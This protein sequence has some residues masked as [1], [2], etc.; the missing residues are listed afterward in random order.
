VAGGASRPYPALSDVS[1][2]APSLAGDVDDAASLA[3]ARSRLSDSV[4]IEPGEG[5]LVLARLTGSVGDV[6]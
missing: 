4:A 5:L 2:R 1:T 6:G 3:S